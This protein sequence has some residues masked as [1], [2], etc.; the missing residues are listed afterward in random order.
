MCPGQ[1]IADKKILILTQL[2]APSSGVGALRSTFFSKYLPVFGWEP[3]VLTSSEDY[4]PLLNT[5][6]SGLPPQKNIIRIPG[7]N[8]SLDDSISFRLNRLIRLFYLP[9]TAHT[10]KLFKRWLSVG[11]D[12]VN[13]I[14]P[15]VIMASSGPESSYLAA[16]TLS[17]RSGIPYIIDFRDIAE[18]F[19]PETLSGKLRIKQIIKR[20]EKFTTAAAACTTVSEGLAD[21]LYSESGIKAYV[22]YNGFDHEIHSSIKSTL[23]DYGKFTVCYVGRIWDPVHR[24]PRP[25]FTAI[26]QLISNNNINKNSFLIQFVGTEPELV[27]RFADGFT[28]AGNITIVPRVSYEESI[29]Y[30]MSANVLLHLSHRQQKGVLTTKVFDYM[31]AGRPILSIPG[32]G[33]EL[34]NLLYRTGSGIPAEDIDSIAYFLND[35]YNRYTHGRRLQAVGSNLPMT[36]SR[37][38]STKILSELLNTII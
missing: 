30:M 3:F 15:D 6:I 33:D 16:H 20:R 29:R 25:L 2:F 11:M 1:T 4:H 14:Q 34:D 26:D 13:E 17:K 22:V 36:F 12:V 18:Q 5:N 23:P 28:C 32:D 7:T 21:Q 31:A 38:E 19:L 9:E 10:A 27:N 24:D 35:H 37:L 8:Q